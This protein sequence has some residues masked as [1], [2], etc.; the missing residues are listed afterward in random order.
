VPGRIQS[1]VAEFRLLYEQPPFGR[2]L[3]S[4]LPSFD[5]SHSLAFD[6]LTPCEVDG[7]LGLDATPE[8]FRPNQ[9]PL[10]AVLLRQAPTSI[11]FSR[12]R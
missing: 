7:I 4:R 5:L 3:S 11:A 6:S 12:Y 10:A 1:G 2:T 9:S 8:S